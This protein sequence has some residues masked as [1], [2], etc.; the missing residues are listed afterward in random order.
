MSP[1][2]RRVVSLLNG[3]KLPKTDRCDRVQSQNLAPDEEE[4]ACTVFLASHQAQRNGGGDTLC[5]RTPTGGKICNMP[6][7]VNRLKSKSPLRPEREDCQPARP[8]QYAYI[9]PVRVAHP[10]SRRLVGANLLL[11]REDSP[12]VIVLWGTVRDWYSVCISYLN[13]RKTIHICAHMR[14]RQ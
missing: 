8:P 12:L 11:R 10:P 1:D 6:T 9:I 3:T 4:N 2:K 13:A 14:D 5:Q 7:M